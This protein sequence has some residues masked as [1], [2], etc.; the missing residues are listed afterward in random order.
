[1][2]HKSTQRCPAEKSA[3]PSIMAF[4]ALADGNRPVFR[5]KREA[6][7]DGLHKGSYQPLPGFADE[8]MEWDDDD[9][10]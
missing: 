3:A 1:M 10:G 6:G 4:I 8:Y 2:N 9:D 7:H 5:C